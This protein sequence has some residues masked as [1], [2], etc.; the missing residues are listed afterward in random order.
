M[1]YYKCFLCMGQPTFKVS[2]N[3]DSWEESQKHYMT[4]H[5]KEPSQNA[6]KQNSQGNRSGSNR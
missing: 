3:K 1:G 5:Y 2:D 4:Y 6:Q